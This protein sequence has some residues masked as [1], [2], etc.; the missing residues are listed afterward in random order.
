MRRFL[1]GDIYGHRG[2]AQASGPTYIAD[3]LQGSGLHPA[4]SCKFPGRV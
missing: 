3:E 2:M 4:I 1:C